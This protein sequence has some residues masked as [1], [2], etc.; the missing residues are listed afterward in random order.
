M[1]RHTNKFTILNYGLASL[2]LSQY[3]Y[4]S[5]PSF[6]LF[7]AISLPLSP[8]LSTSL[9]L[10]TILLDTLQKLNHI[11]QLWNLIMWVMYFHVQYCKIY[12]SMKDTGFEKVKSA[13][14]HKGQYGILFVFE[15]NVISQ[16]SVF[17]ISK[18]SP[19]R[20]FVSF[21]SLIFKW[22]MIHRVTYRGL[23]GCLHSCMY[24]YVYVNTCM[25]VCTCK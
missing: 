9:P 6:F 7:L 3:I 16:L 12:L 15:I 4:L 22:T 25:R 11:L 8:F 14:C 2:F 13:P 19:S 1:K 5:P 20:K 17:D 18:I 21:Y 24:V 23:Y 10:T